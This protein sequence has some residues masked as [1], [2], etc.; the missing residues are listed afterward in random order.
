MLRSL[1]GSEM[2]IRDSFYNPFDLSLSLF[3]LPKQTESKLKC[4]QC[5]SDKKW[6]DCD[7]FTSVTCMGDQTQCAYIQLKQKTVET[8]MRD[9]VPESFCKDKPPCKDDKL[10]KCLIKCC[11]KDECNAG[12][13]EF[14]D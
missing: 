2:C 8:Y 12:K 7:D 13:P 1:V 10:D 11:D 14:T 4:W 9:C 5:E 3:L 6:D